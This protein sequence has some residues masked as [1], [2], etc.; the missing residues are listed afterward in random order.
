MPL[1]NFQSLYLH[2]INAGPGFATPSRYSRLF[3]TDFEYF[4]AC[5]SKIIRINKLSFVDTQLQ[6]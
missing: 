6:N 2:F 5:L 4:R 3:F 1:R